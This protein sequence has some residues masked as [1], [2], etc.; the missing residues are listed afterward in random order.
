ML[1]IVWKLLAFLGVL[2]L[3]LL[4][5][6]LTLL[7]LILFFP[8][9][10]R[11][12]G[13]KHGEDIR[14]VIRAD[15]L[16]GCLRVRGSYPEPGRLKAKLLWRTLYDSEKK[17]AEKT[18]DAGKKES[19]KEGQFGEAQTSK[20][21]EGQPQEAQTD[22]SQEGQPQE[23]QTD[24]SQERQPREAQTDKTQGGQSQEAR[25]DNSQETQKPTENGS[26]SQEEADG[27]QKDRAADEKSA[28]GEYT[29]ASVY[30]KMKALG[31][32]AAYY[33]AL[34]REEETRQLF[35]HT[36]FRCGKILKS[37][38]PR[39]IRAELLIGTGEPDT[40]GYL[41]AL[42]GMASPMLGSEVCVTPDFT[43]AVL[44]GSLF[45]AGHLTGAVLLFHACCVLFDKK[46]RGFIDKMKA[47]RSK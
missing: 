41:L 32:K 13:E 3:I 2:L 10:Y 38:R 40:T 44:E 22:N 5:L 7:L 39:R 6:A 34:L 18:G 15:W 35:L 47:G 12:K 28:H 36:C 24:S 26:C 9:F 30:D 1:G 8:V 17:K 20:P 23:A 19:E 14:L 45:A 21:Q 27:E 42:F 43:A 25:T 31:D 33:A 4:G 29:S 37:I 46:L 16:F 11:V